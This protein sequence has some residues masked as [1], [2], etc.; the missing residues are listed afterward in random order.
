[1][2]KV[3]DHRQT[4][5][6]WYTLWDK[7]EFFAPKVDVKKKPYTIIMPPPNA[8]GELHIGHATFIAIEDILIRFHRM[9]GRPALWL[10]G[11]DHAGILTQVVYERELEKQG[12]TRFDLGRE[13]FF[14]Q[15]YEF[16]M[17]NRKRMEAQLKAL[18]ASCDWAREKFTLDSEISKA[19]YTTFKKLYDKG[20]ICRG[21]RIINWCSRCGTALSDLEVA[22]EEKKGT[23]WYIRYPMKLGSPIHGSQPRNKASKLHNFITVATTRPETMLGDTAVAVN[24]GDKRFKEL[25]GQNATLPLMNREIP[26]IT[27]AA[28]DMRFGTGAVKVTPAHDP[29]D[30]EIGQRNSL[31]TVSVIGQDGCISTNAGEFSG[32]K[33]AVGRQKIVEKLEKQKLIEKVEDYTHTV[34]I[35]ERCR[36]TV[37]PLVSKQWFVKTKPLADPA[38]DAVKKGSIK[39]LPKRFEKIYFNWLEDIRDWCISRQI[40]WG[41]RLPVY[42][43][44]EIKN[45]KCKMK[46]GT[47]VSIETPKKCPFCKASIIEQDPDT[48][49]TWF[50]SG[51]WPFTTLG[52]PNQT[53]DFKYFYPTSVME[54]GYDILFFWVARMI[55][56]GIYATGKPPFH[57]VFLHGL[58]RD[59]RGQ[60]MSKSKG[61]VIDPLE[62]AEKYGADAVRMALVFGTSPGNDVNL[63]ESK[64]RGMRNFT[65]K[66]WNIGRF[67]IDT[68]P[69]SIKNASQNKEDKRIL[70]E[71][72]E[73]KKDVTKSIENYRFGQA[74]EDLYKFIWHKF[75]DKYIEHAKTRREEAQPIL[76]KV[77]E[78]SLQLL[79][80]FMPFIT[81]DLW[82]RLP[83]KKVR[84]IMVSSWPNK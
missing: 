21:E 27:D 56:L 52:W 28:V 54:T 66:I 72:E 8:N 73:T 9:R 41:H 3:Y 16:T 4:E 39:I 83:N 17:K 71:L 65:N 11:A 70:N 37:E 7:K 15:T 5:N 84:S 55:M 57:T 38:I 32:L 75:A 68:K 34:G 20:L 19:V 48:L 62:V 6:K 77:F 33:I 31:E 67:I 36:S 42:Y 50:S 59:E 13:S 44:Q 61:N 46:N 60:K 18:G 35:C 23:L 47:F 1:M 12:K 81:E 80:P 53:E 26:I 29:T 40:W 79:H 49:D 10:P 30:F 43:C 63:G 25:V 64:I 51:Q 14:K 82:Q 78:E 2:D 76:E 58:V 45:V 24:P 69:S 74:A 22:H